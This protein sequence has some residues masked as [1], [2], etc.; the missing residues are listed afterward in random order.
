MPPDT[1]KLQHCLK[2][3]IEH[4]DLQ[5][6]SRPT[7]ELAEASNTLQDELDKLIRATGGV[8]DD[9]QSNQPTSEKS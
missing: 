2:V 1:T 9:K 4:L 6:A 5:M 7:K 8:T 3:A